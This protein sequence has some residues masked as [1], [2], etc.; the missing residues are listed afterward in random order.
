ME[1]ADERYHIMKKREK[2]RVPIRWRLY[3]SSKLHAYH[4]QNLSRFLHRAI[5]IAI[6]IIYDYM[7][8]FSLENSRS[9]Q[10]HKFVRILYIPNDEG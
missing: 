6:V 9:L 7:R 1:I 4:F 8:V 3:V 10:S 5:A 2:E